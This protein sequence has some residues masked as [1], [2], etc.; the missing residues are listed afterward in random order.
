MCDL[1]LHLLMQLVIVQLCLSVIK[2]VSGD[3]AGV[4][5]NGSDTQLD[6]DY[7]LDKSEVTL[8]FS[9]YESERETAWL[10]ISG[11]L[12]RLQDLMTSCHICMST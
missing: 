10:T 9:G 5:S 7:Q 2:M 12:A 1:L 6:I 8:T 11:Q 4:V 3:V